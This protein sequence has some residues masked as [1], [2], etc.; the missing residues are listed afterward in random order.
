MNPISGVRQVLKAIAEEVEVL[1]A[2]GGAVEDLERPDF[3][4]REDQALNLRERG[5]L[6]LASHHASCALARTPSAL[7]AHLA[8]APPGG[9]LALDFTPLRHE[10]PRMEGVDRVWSTAHKAPIWGYN[11]HSAP[12]FLGLRILGWKP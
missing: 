11:R 3:E 7:E 9:V 12:L 6:P 5:F 4:E 10:G 1:P 2:V 8:Q